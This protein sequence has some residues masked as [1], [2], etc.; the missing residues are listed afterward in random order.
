MIHAALKAFYSPDDAV[1]FLAERL[2]LP[3]DD[4]GR[5]EKLIAEMNSGESAVRDAAFKQLKALDLK[6]ACALGIALHAPPDSPEVRIR[7]E[8]LLAAMEDPV[9]RTRE[10][11]QRSR[12]IHVLALIG[13]E[14]ARK[15]LDEIAKHSPL[16]S[17]REEAQKALAKSK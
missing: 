7:V 17:E 13:T 2:K 9:F 10:L 16:R 14:Y 6:A 4:N 11:E 5:A 3:A 1:R 8:K 12:A 15:T